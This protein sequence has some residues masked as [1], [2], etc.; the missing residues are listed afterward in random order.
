MYAGGMYYSAGWGFLTRLVTGILGLMIGALGIVR[1]LIES[2]DHPKRRSSSSYPKPHI[3]H[4]GGLHFLFHY[5][6][7]TPIY[8]YI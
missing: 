4:C 8:P 3:P 6:Y 1:R 5:P 2:K 7:I